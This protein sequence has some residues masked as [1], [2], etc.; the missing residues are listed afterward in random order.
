LKEGER[1]KVKRKKDE[2][3]KGKGE[4]RKH[5]LRLHPFTF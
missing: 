5:A 2:L 3:K 1:R 4:D